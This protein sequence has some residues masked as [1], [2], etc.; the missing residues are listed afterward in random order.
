[1]LSLFIEPVIDHD[2]KITDQD[3]D[4]IYAHVS[5]V[6]DD[7]HDDIN[8]QDDTDSNQHQDNK[9]KFCNVNPNFISSQTYDPNQLSVFSHNFTELDGIERVLKRIKEIKK[10]MVN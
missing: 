8:I 10:K 2:F 9:S 6:A 7:N 1:M 4:F 5:I 3:Q